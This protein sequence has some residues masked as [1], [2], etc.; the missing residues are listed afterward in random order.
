MIVFLES[1]GWPGNVVNNEFTS[2]GYNFSVRSNSTVRSG[3]FLS[4]G[5]PG[6]NNCAWKFLD[7]AS[8]AVGGDRSSL[9]FPVKTGI[10]TAT[11]GFV[12][13]NYTFNGIGMM[14]LV[15]TLG[16]VTLELLSN[17]LVWDFNSGQKTG[18][19]PWNL[20]TTDILNIPWNYV[21]VS[22]TP[23][24]IILRVNNSEID[25]F[26]GTGFTGDTYPF[27]GSRNNMSLSGNYNE[28]GGYFGD[29][30]LA[31]DD[32]FRGD[33]YVRLLPLT[34]TVTNTGEKF[35][36]APTVHEGVKTFS[37][38]DYVR[39]DTDGEETLLELGDIADNPSNI[40]GV[41]LRYSTYKTETDNVLATPYLT[42]A[43]VPVDL[44]SHSPGPGAAPV[45]VPLTYDPVDS[46]PWTKAKV[47][48][49]KMGIK[50]TD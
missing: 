24:L 8:T 37:N 50:K 33:S 6:S 10:P 23:T 22:I 44:A 3:N 21:E 16:S 40:H 38:V 18:E 17:K 46:S 1:F 26:S 12:I 41:M 42:V 47:N 27:I 9:T 4:G 36:P 20:V 25:R 43:G 39:Y 49:L 35:G 32:I 31:D 5:R 48:A 30:Y 7:S 13:G 34:A 45:H 14:G 29:F 19:L 2:R 28:A 11:C 15:F